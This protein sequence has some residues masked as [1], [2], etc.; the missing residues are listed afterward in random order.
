MIA[1]KMNLIIDV[2]PETIY[3][4]HQIHTEKKNPSQ[5]YSSELEI[6]SL[7][8]ARSFASFL[9]LAMMLCMVR[10]IVKVRKAYDMLVL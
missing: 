3:V 5:R 1:V 6:V 8:F 4:S 7:S 9:M 10:I 2:F